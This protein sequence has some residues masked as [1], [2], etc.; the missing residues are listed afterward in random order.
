[1][2]DVPRRKSRVRYFR[3]LSLL[4]ILN[5]LFSTRNNGSYELT[6]FTKSSQR[7]FAAET[8][9]YWVSFV[10]SGDPNVYALP[11]SPE[12]PKWDNGKGKGKRMVLAQGASTTT[13]A[14]YVSGSGIEDQPL[15][16]LERCRAVNAMASRLHF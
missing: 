11:G 13:G 16:E 7:H 12:W 8:I 3:D 10:R 4:T 1:M 2:V 14:G 15:K 5:V 9:A 6:P